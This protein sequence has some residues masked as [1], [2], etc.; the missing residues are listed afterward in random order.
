MCVRVCMCVCVSACMYLCVR[1]CVCVYVCLQG[2]LAALPVPYRTADNER[3]L[4]S[5]TDPKTGQSDP[6]QKKASMSMYPFVGVP[7]GEG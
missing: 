2:P 4:Q 7:L 6:H 5:L 3:T 1:A